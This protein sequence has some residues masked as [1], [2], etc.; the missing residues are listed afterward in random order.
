MIHITEKCVLIHF[1]V[2]L[3]A[4][5]FNEKLILKNIFLR[6]YTIDTDRMLPKLHKQD[7]NLKSGEITKSLKD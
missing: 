4:A 1:S 2:S 7:S 3:C 6:V 5:V